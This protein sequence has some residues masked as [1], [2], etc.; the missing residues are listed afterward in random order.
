MNDR[1][2]GA[3]PDL[4]VPML[5]LWHVALLLV[6]LVPWEHG[7]PFFFIVTGVSCVLINYLNKNRATVLQRCLLCWVCMVKLVF[8]LSFLV[9]F[10]V[11][12]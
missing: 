5:V 4:L 6:L 12:C 9:K 3:R 2:Q 7:A 11:G 1:P 10:W 8:A